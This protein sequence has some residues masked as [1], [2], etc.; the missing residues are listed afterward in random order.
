MNKIFNARLDLDAVQHHEATTPVQVGFAPVY[1]AF[2]TPTT[3][4]N[5]PSG[6]NVYAGMD[7]EGN[8]G[9]CINRSGTE[10]CF[11]AGNA[12]YEQQHVQEVFNEPN[13]CSYDS[14]SGNWNCVASDFDCSVYDDGD[15][16]CADNSDSSE[17]YVTGGGSVYCG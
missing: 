1:F 8:K 3:D 17:C 2:G 4:T 5:R 12:A 13:Q 10:Y 15:V 6:K 14:E 16:G 7:A 9:V 11:Q